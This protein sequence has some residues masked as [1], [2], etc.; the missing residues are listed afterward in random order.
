MRS[1][2]ERFRRWRRSRQQPKP[3]A[4]Y[5]VVDPEQLQIVLKKL[6]AAT[7]E[8]KR[9][10]AELGVQEDEGD[11]VELERGRL[12]ME[13]KNRHLRAERAEHDE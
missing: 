3:V 5:V 2:I 9:K 8:A 1:L 11:T 4:G 7:P 12:R 10:L 6:V 13:R